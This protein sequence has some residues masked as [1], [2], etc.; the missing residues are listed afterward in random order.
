MLIPFP[1]LIRKYNI[2]PKGIFHCGANLSQEIDW[3]YDN[4]VERSVWIEAIPDVYKQM[5]NIISKYPK[6]IGINACISDE[7]GKEVTFN[8]ASN[9]GESSSMLDFGTHSTMHPDVTF[10]DSIKLKTKRLDAIILEKSINIKEFDFLNLDLQGSELLA[11]KGCGDYLRMFDYVYIELNRDELYKGCAKF[12]EVN[13]YLIKFGF[14]LKEI[15]WTGAGWGDGF[16]MK[17]K[18]AMKQSVFRRLH[19]SNDNLLGVP[20]KFRPHIRFPYPPDNHL[21]FEEWYG[22]HYN[23]LTDKRERQYLPVYWTSF[24]VNHSFGEDKNAVSELQSFVDGLDRSKKYYTICQFDFGCM[25]DFKD[26]DIIVFGMAGGRI[27]YKLPLICQPHEFEFDNPKTIFANFIGRRTH[28]IR[29]KVIDGLRGKEGCYV[30]EAKHDLSA[31]CSIISHSIFTIA[32][33]G[34]GFDSFRAMEALQYGSIPVIISNERHEPHGVPF[35]NYAYYIDE[36][37]AGNVYEILKEKLV[38]EVQLKQQ[39][40]KYFYDTYFSYQSNKK[41]ILSELSKH[42]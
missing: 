35:E 2:K 8:I 39:A 9:H 31:Y 25:V 19:G 33:R 40:L 6:T 14:E 18:E 30:S 16:Y 11:L 17:N 22:Q 38:V 3:Y 41:L 5:K 12:D 28:P 1:E 13:A 32:P 7:N 34:V 24:L 27:D 42:N 15:K 4:G 37:D 10:I 26:L 20:N 23:D 36:K 21:I 29:D